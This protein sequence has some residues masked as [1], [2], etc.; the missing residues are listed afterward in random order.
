MTILL[1]LCM[2]ENPGI[3]KPRFLGVSEQGEGGQRW[4]SV[5]SA[6]CPECRLKGAEQG[7]PRGRPLEAQ[8]EF[9]TLKDCA[10]NVVCKHLIL[11]HGSVKDLRNSH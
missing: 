3:G 4:V 9:K 1:E 5:F 8:W 2:A 10:F 11:S 7:S 6:S